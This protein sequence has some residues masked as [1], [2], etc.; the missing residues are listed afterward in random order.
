MSEL[1][2]EQIGNTATEQGAFEQG[3]DF[4]GI[5]HSTLPESRPDPIEVNA[6]YISGDGITL[7]PVGKEGTGAEFRLALGELHEGA[8]DELTAQ[9]CEEPEEAPGTA[10]AMRKIHGI[11]VQGNPSR[12]EML[13]K[14]APREMLVWYGMHPEYD[15]AV[16][17]DRIMLLRD[18]K[19]SAYSCKACK[20]IGYEEDAVCGNCGG[21]AKETIRAEGGMAEVPCRACRVLGYGHEQGYS[22]GH[23]KC[24]KCN[25]SGWHGGII[26]PEE[27][28]KEAITGIVVSLGPETHTYKIGDRLM[29]SR[30]A[31]HTMEISKTTSYIIMHESEAIGIL[32][33]KAERP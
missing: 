14:R 13:S 1:R 15:G 29:F 3:A 18:I 10:M 16:A 22:S 30:F 2:R 5:N 28:Q 17:G 33:Q 7:T 32:R 9:L 19:E 27:S 23:K 31:G 11:E 4:E 26:I 20:G 6:E 8:V 12:L 21:T 25:G 24:S